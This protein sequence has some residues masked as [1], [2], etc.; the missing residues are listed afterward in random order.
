MSF[1]AV[2]DQAGDCSRGQQEQAV[3]EEAE[4]HKLKVAYPV[5]VQEQWLC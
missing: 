4:Q 1:A 5:Q 3:A 2:A